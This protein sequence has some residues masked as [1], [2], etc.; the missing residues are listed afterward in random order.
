M[1]TDAHVLKIRTESTKDVFPLNPDT[2]CILQTELL[3][4][5]SNVLM[6]KG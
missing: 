4:L 2:F 5:M 3:I 6:S 1:T